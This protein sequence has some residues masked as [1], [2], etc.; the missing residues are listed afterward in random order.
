[1]KTKDVDDKTLRECEEEFELAEGDYW[2]QCP[3]ILQTTLDVGDIL[4]KVHQS[5]PD[6]ASQ[7]PEGITGTASDDAGNYLCDFIHYSSL[8]HFRKE[9]GESGKRPVVFLC[10]PPES[11]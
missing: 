8:S 4:D 10:M 1:M 5:R 11:N 3:E 7:L 6:G 2:G 9:N